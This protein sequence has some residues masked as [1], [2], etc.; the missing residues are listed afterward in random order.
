MFAN[1][2]FLN[3]FSCGESSQFDTPKKPLLAV[4]RRIAPLSELTFRKRVYSAGGGNR[5]FDGGGLYLE[6]RPSGAKL[7]RLKYRFADREQLLSLGEYP[8][9]S[10][11]QARSKRAEI[12]ALIAQ[13][14]DPSLQRRRQKLARNMEVANTFEAVAREWIDRF[15]PDWAD[16]HTRSIMVRLENDVFP[17]IGRH[18]IADLAAP[19]LLAVLRRVEKR[20]ALETATRIRQYFSQIFRYAVATARVPRDPAAD[21]KGALRSPIPKRY[22]TMTDPQKIGQLLRAIDGYEGHPVTRAALQLTPLV[23]VRPGELRGA[24]WSEI[25]FSAAEWRI[26]AIRLK[27]KMS[28]KLDARQ[29]DHVVPL[30]RQALA[31]LEDLQ[32]FTGDGIFLFPSVRTS[33]RPM[34]DNTINAALRRMGY[35]KDEIVGHGFRHM[36]STLL[37][38]QGWSA[39]AIERQLAHK[40]S[41]VRAI[42]NLA[43]YMPERRR[44]MQAWA[45]YLDTLKAGGKPVI[46]D[47]NAPG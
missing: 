3:D 21:L 42:Y 27:M 44:M 11:T 13:G 20:G 12:K 46:P 23:F 6:L 28:A 41:G 33:Q 34:S 18:P 7:W 25:D 39:D 4:A 15:S 5:L 38:E 17:W 16:S 24:A 43:E 26:P 19:E 22:A 37:N 31:I 14:I 8:A 2:L 45:D 40:E 29:S 35:G 10:S 1:S 47:G 36:A 30:S 9:V 32:P